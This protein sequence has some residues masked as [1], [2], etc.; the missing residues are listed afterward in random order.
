MTIAVSIRA[1]VGVGG[2]GKPAPNNPDDVKKV[3]D[4]LKKALGTNAPRLTPGKVDPVFCNAI[5]EFQKL[6]GGVADSTV[7]PRGRTLQ[8][9]NLISTPIKLNG[10]KPGP[11][12]KGGYIISYEDQLQSVGGLPKKGYRLFLGIGDDNTVMEVSGRNRADL[13]GSDNL[14]ELLKL[15]AKKNKWGSSVDCKLHLKYGTAPVSQSNAQP[16]KCPVAPYADG[17]TFDAIAKAIPKMTYPGNGKGRLLTDL[18]GAKRYFK[19]GG[20]FETDN[21]M[22]GFDC[23]T[24][25]IAL[26]SCNINMGDKHGTPLADALGATKCSMEQKKPEE[27]KA[28]FNDATTGAKGLYFMWSAGHIILA[29]DATIHEF[30]YGGYKRTAASLWEGYP[31]APQKLWWVRKLPSTYAP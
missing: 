24:F 16:L 3:H 8:R 29:K 21:A 7:D 22:R 25:P 30:T 17:L 2:R 12:S 10:V 18:I 31:K 19:Y 11:V 1:A 15:I 23:T 13:I 4:L 6:W 14:P 27:V 5:A 26:F 20:R 9:L 28:F